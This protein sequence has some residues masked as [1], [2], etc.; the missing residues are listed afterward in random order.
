MHLLWRFHGW[1]EKKFENFRRG[2]GGLLVWSLDNHIAVMVGFLVLV[3]VS[4]CLLFPL[5]GEDFFPTVDAGQIRLHVRCPPGTRIEETE[6][7]YAAVEAV[8]H[9]IIPGEEVAVMLDNMGIPNSSINLCL[10]DETIGL[11]R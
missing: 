8:I 7:N 9:K 10:S 6:N 5:I 2:Y 4:L 3:A 1:F 11:S